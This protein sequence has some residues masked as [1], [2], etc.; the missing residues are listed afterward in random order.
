MHR[1]LVILLLFLPAESWSDVVGEERT[2]Y[3]Q[4]L[5]IEQEPRGLWITPATTGTLDT[6]RVYLL[7]QDN[8]HDVRC[9]VYRRSDSSFVDS[10]TVVECA[11]DTAWYAFPFYENS[12]I[13][14]DTTY[15]LIAYSADEVTNCKIGFLYSSDGYW[16]TDAYEGSPMGAWPDTLDPTFTDPDYG[17]CIHAIYTP[18][19]EEEAVANCVHCPEGAGVVHSPE[20]ASTVHEP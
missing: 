9:A 11:V 17:V 20:G 15:Y 3:D 5:T 1:W 16:F 12:T 14:A 6:A 10:T 18:E 8:A 13:K 7:V 2:D 4:I 19:A